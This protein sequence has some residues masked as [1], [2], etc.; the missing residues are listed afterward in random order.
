MIG[1]QQLDGRVCVILSVSEEGKKKNGGSYGSGVPCVNCILSYRGENKSKKKKEL[2]F[3]V[4][5][6]F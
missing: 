3:R 2:E 4:I 1:Q 5:P 6:F